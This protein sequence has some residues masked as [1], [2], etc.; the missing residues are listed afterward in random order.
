MS[1]LMDALRKA[2]EA[3]K[4]AELESKSKPVVA[5]PAAV[6]VDKSLD[7][8]IEFEQPADV[9][10]LLE[11]LPASIAASE[12]A[13]SASEELEE[14]EELEESIAAYSNRLS[15]KA[16]EGASDNSKDS[17]EDSSQDTAGDI[18]SENEQ[19]TRSR[20]SPTL[21]L[22]I[23]DEAEYDAPSLARQTPDYT[24]PATSKAQ[25][26]ADTATAKSKKAESR[27]NF[28]EV[29]AVPPKA[30]ARDS[31]SIDFDSSPTVATASEPVPRA[32]P[33]QSITQR[34]RAQRQPDAKVETLDTSLE[35]QDRKSARS[36]FAAKRHTSPLKKNLQLTAISIAAV[37]LVAIG[38]YFY[39]SLRT[40]SG[41]A[42]PL[43]ELANQQEPRQFTEAELEM[44]DAELG[45][46]TVGIDI[47]DSVPE[48]INEPE[49]VANQPST[50]AGAPVRTPSSPPASDSAGT[51]AIDTAAVT[52]N[53]PPVA[54]DNGA[55]V[56]VAV[57][58]AVI[59]PV[60]QGV[61]QTP[62][63]TVA[64]PIAPAR[65]VAGT[66]ATATADTSTAAGNTTG[67][68]RGSAAPAGTA[69][70][71]SL[72]PQRIEPESLV[73]FTRR[74]A[75]PAEIPLV[76]NAYTAYQNGNLEQ[77]ERLYREA[78]VAAPLN[79]S[80]L[81]GLA[82]IAANR[83]DTVA[84]L[85][86]YSRLLA[87]DPSDPVAKAGILE[88]MPSGNL[89]QQEA[90]LRRLQTQHPGVAPLA[91]AFGNFLASQQRWSEAQQAYFSALQQ[92]KNDAQGST[93]NPD[94]AFN[95]AV[96]LEHLGQSRAAGNYYREALTLAEV[97]PAGFS[98]GL[99]RERLSSTESA[100]NE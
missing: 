10:P 84:A 21:Q 14:L 31:Y 7:I 2:E 44:A 91:Y 5:R 25:G 48:V 16:A 59:P 26:P 70:A 77:A 28:P 100:I 72:Q 35:E 37:L 89:Q 54:N 93:V 46:G 85:E 78:L 38:I 23:D 4:K 94:Y 33:L 13:A 45:I 75:A 49:V 73:S 66:S 52:A 56:A 8:E 68:N 12:E 86:L 15:E 51:P 24:R 87:R 1:L 29:T 92:A 9:E 55:S 88:I 74:T 60:R 71:A 76:E 62:P 11:D 19:G 79:R 17:S 22:A 63:E 43:A 97:H 30:A 53:Q 3:K 40:G 65:P 39:I 99:A 58:R 82:A 27:P 41:I 32:S 81:L 57:N 42:F 34:I 69:T 47:S 98:L 6:D 67:A 95:L 20:F 50:L 96:S 61:V 18:D 36:V 90:E 64:N 83:N 80:A